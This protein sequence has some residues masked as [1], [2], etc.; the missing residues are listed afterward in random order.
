[1]SF[2]VSLFCFSLSH[3]AADIRFYRFLK[4]RNRRSLCTYS[5]ILLF[6]V[7]SS[8]SV[9]EPKTLANADAVPKVNTSVATNAEPAPK[10]VDHFDRPEWPGRYGARVL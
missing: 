3:S 2:G 5:I 6:A 8:C 4:M 1:M 7:V 9:A 10:G